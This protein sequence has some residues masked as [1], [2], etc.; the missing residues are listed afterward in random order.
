MPK[1]DS[2]ATAEAP[3]PKEFSIVG[4]GAS[5]G[6]LEACSA[7]L[8]NLPLDTGLAFVVIQ[9]LDPNH[10]SMLPKLL[11]RVTKIPVKT[12]QDGMAVERNQVYVMPPTWEIVFS[13][14]VLRL[15]PREKTSA[16]THMPIDGFFRSLAESC[17]HRAIGV[18]CRAPVPMAPWDSK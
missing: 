15:I 14:G 18:F 11:A 7:L 8:K 16:G 3:C 12:V 1:I 2:A 5:A 6:G 13:E 10:E 17:Q 9:H 4:I